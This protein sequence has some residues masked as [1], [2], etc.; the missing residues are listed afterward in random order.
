MLVDKLPESAHQS[1]RLQL[2]HVL[3]STLF[4]AACGVQRPNDRT[5]FPVGVVPAVERDTY[6]AFAIGSPTNPTVETTVELYQGPGELRS[7]RSEHNAVSVTMDKLC[8]PPATTIKADNI[9]ALIHSQK[10][11]IRIHSE[12]CSAGFLDTHVR[13]AEFLPPV[14]LHNSQKVILRF[15][16]PL[17]PLTQGG[18]L[19]CTNRS[20]HLDGVGR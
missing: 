11:G 7:L 4:A 20:I 18:G 10:C 5:S 19:L 12:S 6:I 8:C 1:G 17:D 15:S 3:L 16:Y 2:R 14:S 9:A 13:V